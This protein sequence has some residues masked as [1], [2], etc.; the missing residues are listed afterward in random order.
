MY[1]GGDFR[2]LRDALTTRGKAVI[3]IG[4][5]APRVHEALSDVVR[6]VDASSMAD[7]VKKGFEAAQPEG[8]V[9]LA[10]ACSSFDWFR[11]YAERGTVFKREVAAL[12]DRRDS[13]AGGL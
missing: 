11:D 2:D 5:A 12:R 8:V 1:K 7:A 9:L 3:A 10:P 13:E 4:E 6:V